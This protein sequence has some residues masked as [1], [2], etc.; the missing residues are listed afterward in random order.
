VASPERRRRA[1]E[2]IATNFEHIPA[3]LIA[4]QIV[5]VAACDDVGPMLET[6]IREG[7]NL[8]A[9]GIDCP[10]RIVWGTKDVVLPWPEA[11]VRFRQEWLPQT[12]YVVLD[13]VGHCP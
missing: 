1:T 10:V 12:E 2:F 4:H 11:A 9:S 8:D 6:A 3:G 7:W 13:G 5:G